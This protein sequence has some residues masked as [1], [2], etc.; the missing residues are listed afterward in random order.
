MKEE[1]KDIE[2]AK[3]IDWQ[4]DREE[5]WGTRVNSVYF[6]CKKKHHGYV[7]ISKIPGVT[8]TMKFLITE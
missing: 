3:E 7:W 4:I 5:G 2:K 6:Q 8:I 1:K